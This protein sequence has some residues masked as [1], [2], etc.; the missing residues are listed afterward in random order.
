MDE[1]L[2]WR[3]R[4]WHEADENGHDEDADAACKAVFAAVGREPVV[5]ADFA[6]RTVAAVAAATARDVRR[7]RRT[8]RVTTGVAVVAG[9]V[10]VYAAG[11]WALSMFS[12]VLV[13]VLDVLVGVTV[14][15]VV[16]LQAGTD[17]WTVLANL[18]RAAAA[19][20]ADPSITVAIFAMQ[21]IAMAALI[22]LRRL[23]D[24]DRGSFK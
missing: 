7:A 6:S 22:A 5:S 9:A 10:G 13:R 8:R 21:A 3:Y 12:S 1:H 11:G 2:T 23:L 17:V 14:R 24:P 18:G 16:G 15:A 19:F 4:R 20:A